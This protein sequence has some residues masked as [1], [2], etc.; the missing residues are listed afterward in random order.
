MLTACTGKR[1]W[2]L[3]SGISAMTSVVCSYRKTYWQRME[4]YCKVL[5]S[6]TVHIRLKAE[7][8]RLSVWFLI[9]SKCTLHGSSSVICLRVCCGLRAAL[10][11]WFSCAF[12]GFRRREIWLY[13]LDT[14]ESVWLGKC[15][16]LRESSGWTMLKLN[17]SHCYSKPGLGLEKMTNDL[18]VLERCLNS[19]IQLPLCSF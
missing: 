8:A 2:I 13:G 6:V 5:A 9:V 3:E 17:L 10:S 12:W 4:F 7:S 15:S 18:F 11:P 16:A 19:L 1:S 14:P